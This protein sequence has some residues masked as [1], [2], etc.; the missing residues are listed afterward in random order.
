MDQIGTPIDHQDLPSLRATARQAPARTT[1]ME[2][3]STILSLSVQIHDNLAP[4]SHHYCIKT[5]HTACLAFGNGLRLEYYS[6][7]R[8]TKAVGSAGG[9]RALSPETSHHPCAPAEGRRRVP[10]HNRHSRL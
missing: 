10:E 3:E 8:R 7:E 4:Y 2:A 5:W 6:A 9:S 1:T